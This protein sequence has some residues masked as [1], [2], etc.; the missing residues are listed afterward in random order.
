MITIENVSFFYGQE[1]LEER[2]IHCINL[3]IE[4][5]EFIVLCGRSGCGKTTLTR[6]INGLVPHFYEGRMN[7]KVVVDGEEVAKMPLAK[8]ATKI[9][10]VFQ[11]PRS[12]FFNVDTT[13]ELAF[14]CENM[15]MEPLEAWGRIDEAVRKFQIE[16][17]MNRNIFE[18]SGGEKQQVACASVY[19][20][21][22]RVFVFD[23]PSSNLDIQSIHRLQNVLK[24][25]KEGGNTIIISEHRLHYLAELA[26]RF[27]Y[28][29]EGCIEGVYSTQ[30]MKELGLEE[31]SKKGLR[32]LDRKNITNK[33][34]CEAKAAKGE[35][36]IISL[37]C[38]VKRKRILDIAGLKLME[39]EIV[40]VVGANG[41]GKSTFARCLC[42][43][44]R[45]RG[46]VCKNGTRFMKKDRLQNSYMVMQDVNHQL[47]TES[48]RDEVTLGIKEV[49]LE[50]AQRVMEELSLEDCMERH[51]LT[52][53]GGQKQRVAIAGALCAGKELLIYDEP[54]SGLDYQSM[55][56]TCGVVRSASKKAFLTLVI[57][58]DL[59]F[60]LECATSVLHI[61][62]GRVASHY[63][64]DRQG[65]QRVK[66]FFE[67]DYNARLERG[68]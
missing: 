8:I 19:A 66:D 17:L 64:L 52:L 2:G 10:S 37:C 58:H 57:T 36:D 41:A 14:G 55:C 23:E 29:K 47:F 30:Q 1:E 12:Q 67:T 46:V 26:D 5:G 61:S 21:R 33:C 50:M 9:G 25:L 24:K 22:P 51:P 53:S 39:G 35:L 28:M 34:E 48:V 38:K 63:P 60:I 31:L 27:V 15:G 49:P 4:T 68:L 16:H 43:I 13:K 18:L 65:V 56:A 54:T 11:N 59:E 7:G 42:G 44:Q 45:H 3:T 40:A 6:V 32:S 20:V 62:E